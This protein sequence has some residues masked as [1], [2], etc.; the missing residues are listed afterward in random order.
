MLA[1]AIAYCPKTKEA[2]LTLGSASVIIISW[3][4]PQLQ[5]FLA[6][7]LK[8]RLGPMQTVCHSRLA[9]IIREFAKPRRRRRGQRRL[10]MDLCFTCESRDTLKSFTLFITV[11]TIAKLN[12]EHSDKFEIK[13]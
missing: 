4:L 10:K 3:K 11:K 7:A 9:S 5:S 12:P 13:F 6:T 8:S 1:I 2:N